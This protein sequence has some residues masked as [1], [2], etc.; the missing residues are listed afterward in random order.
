MLDAAI[1]ADLVMQRKAVAVA[2][3]LVCQVHS[4]WK[5]ASL[6]SILLPSACLFCLVQH[7][8]PIQL[9]MT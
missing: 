7:Q 4:L 5:V 1:H 3:C 2:V 6:Y 8:S 9:A